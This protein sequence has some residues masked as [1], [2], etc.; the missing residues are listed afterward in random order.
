MNFQLR[1]NYEKPSLFCKNNKVTRIN[2]EFM[3]LTKFSYEEV[4]GK[5]LYEVQ[6]ILNINSHICFDAVDNEREYYIFTKEFEAREVIISCKNIGYGVDCNEK[7]YFFMEK[8]SSRIKD[9]FIY[10]DQAYKEKDF[11]AALYSASD[12]ILLNSNQ[13]Y[14]D[15]CNIYKKEE[16]F[17]KRFEQIHHTN[18]W[19]KLNGYFIDVLQTGK[20]FR[21]EFEYNHPK[22]GT[23]YWYIQ[24]I[25]I[26]NGEAIK[27]IIHTI[28]DETE[29]ILNE[30]LIQ[31]QAEVIRAQNENLEAIVQNMSDALYTVDKDMNM[32][33]L[34][35]YMY[36]A[37]LVSDKQNKFDKVFANTKFYDSE[38]NLLTFENLPVN[39][40]LEGESFKDYRLISR[41]ADNTYYLS[42]SGSPLYNR[43]GIIEK[44]MICTRDITQQEVKDGLIKNQKEELEAIIEHISDEVIIVDNKGQY[45]MVNKSCRDNNY[46]ND[47]DPHSLEASFNNEVYLDISGNEI[48]PENLPSKRVARGEMFSGYRMDVKSDKGIIHK[49]I[50][51]SPIYDSKGKFIAG[52]LVMRNIG[53][54]LKDE[55]NKL[56]KAQYALLNRIIENLELSYGI[57]SYPDFKI[58]YIN[59]AAYFNLRLINDEVKSLSSVLGTSIFETFKYSADEKSRIEVDIRK[60]IEKNTSKYVFNRKYIMRGK[61]K[62][63]K[64]MFQP[65]FDL[66]NNVTEI[67]AIEVDITEEIKLKEKIEQDLKIQDEIFT[68]VSHELKTPLNVIFSTNQLLEYYLNNDLLKSYEGKVAKNIGIIKQNCYRFTRLIN[69]IVDSSKIESGFLKLNLVNRNIVEV[70]ENIVQSVSEYIKGKDIDIIFDTNIEEK[71][72]ACDIEKIEKVILNLISNAIKFTNPGGNIFVNL[73]DTGSVI[74]ISVKDTGIGM[75]KIHID[76]IFRRFYQIDKSL[77]RNSEGT[78]IGLFLVKA[79]VELHGGK[80]FVESN[81]G[82][83]SIFKIELPI[84]TI[85]EQEKYTGKIMPINNKVE[86]I[87]IEF[88][89]IYSI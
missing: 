84:Q 34:S 25:P 31:Q 58:E 13:R 61:E 72:I 11:G 16:A 22:R 77:S 73:I 69:N 6:G 62:F 28:A 41:R 44:A 55:E 49:E 59:G 2:K 57:I 19:D 88:S 32:E 35:K 78:G 60:L 45:T 81:P 76:N 38:D 64:I 37:A 74:E 15:Y 79:F 1:S 66:Y 52:V 42:L 33:I 56:I 23:T 20:S 43:H 26:Y 27:Y 53:D 83:G 47:M 87:N 65:L 70:I 67:V 63:F 86:M 29:K 50:S 82:M 18:E 46:L 51:G 48:E 5:S 10:L 89:D 12:L 17:G 40:I 9:K 30:S 85:E 80:I 3:K 7:V 14:L 39:R 68:N 54:R 4:I 36:N 24:I 21:K 8:A 75:D 71:Y